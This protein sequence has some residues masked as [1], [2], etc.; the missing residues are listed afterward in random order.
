VHD[1]HEIYSLLDEA[2]VREQASRCIQCPEP[3]C[4]T[5]CPL[6]NLIPDWL[7]LAAEGRFLEAAALS[8]STSNMPEICSRVCP[9]ERLCEGACILNARSDPVA[10]GAVEKFINEYAFDYDAV[11]ASTVS[12]NGLRVAVVGSGPGGMAC[13]DELAKLGYAVTVFDS[14]SRAGGLLVN[15]IPSFKLEKSVVERRLNLLRRR[16]V[17]FRLGVTVGRDIS[18]AA[19][20]ADFDAVYLALGAQKP[21]PL[22]IPGA[23]LQGVFD[24]LPF[25]IEKNLGEVSSG[26]AINVS[27]KRVVVLG[28]GDTA[29]DC[30]RT[31]IRS[32]AR[33]AVCLYRRDLANMPGSRKEYANALEEGAQFSFLRNP[34]ALLGNADGRV[35]QVRCVRMELGEPDVQGRRK[36]RAI[37]GS[38]FVLP[39]DV[40]LVAYGFDPAPLPVV[41]GSDQIAL[42][43]WGGVIVG[44]NQVT[45]VP[46]VFA[47]GDLTRGPSLVVH[48]V[49][50]GRK[51]AAGIHQYLTAGRMQMSG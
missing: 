8:R 18:L 10:I 22:D 38:D 46:G 31:A 42:S 29:M 15:G 5:G 11:A 45:N 50:D 51:A 25:L 39:A 1:F 30:L 34:I 37:A 35:A 28:G 2:T 12:P 3:L 16:G 6:G 41:S 36:P 26:P 9:Q 48:A 47:G 17:T 44:D 40:V 49:R 19:L 21:K 32:G 13:A 14:Q 33:E 4:R 27:Q 23:E 24:A 7:A 43:A 20:R